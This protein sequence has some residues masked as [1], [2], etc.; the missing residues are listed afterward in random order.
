M[1][2]ETMERLFDPFFSTKF[3]GRGLGLAVALGILKAHDGAI[4][5]DSRLGRGTTV[6]VFF[7]ILTRSHAPQTR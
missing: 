4:A 1:D 2:P 7:K 3:T 5:V 6:R